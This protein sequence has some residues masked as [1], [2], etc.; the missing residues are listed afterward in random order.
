MDLQDLIERIFDAH[1]PVAQQQAAREMR[2]FP[3]NPDVV[4]ILF[5]ACYE[6][7]DPLLQ[8]EAVRSLAALCP[9]KALEAFRK[10]TYSPDAEKRRRALYHLGTLGEPQG[11]EHVLRG[12]SDPDAAVR[13][14]AA[15]SVGRL[16]NDYRVLAAL[17]S[18]LDDREPEP[19]RRAARNAIEQIQ[20]RLNTTRSFD[21][22]PSFKGTRSR[23]PR[24]DSYDPMAF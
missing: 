13:K 3:H 14:A 2:S 4:F 9:A 16:G 12:L 19:V 10:S 15:C 24:G 23:P 8:Q 7:R 5:R 11:L 20:K 21:V 1:D 18:L 17:R 6:A 22:R